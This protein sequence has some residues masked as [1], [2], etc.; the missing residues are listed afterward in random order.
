MW[1][2][3]YP[4]TLDIIY[5][6]LREKSLKVDLCTGEVYSLNGKWRKLTH[7]VCGRNGYHYPSVTIYRFYYRWEHGKK[8]RVCRRRKIAVHKLV[9]IAAYGPIPRGYQVH[10]KDLDRM[11]PELTNLELLTIEDHHDR[12]NAVV[13]VPHAD[14]IW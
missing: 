13:G 10:H 4:G 2:P 14:A 11:N 6:R 3:T 7:T 1:P 12:H 9:W 8:V 5:R